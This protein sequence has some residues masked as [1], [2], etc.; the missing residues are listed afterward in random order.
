MEK[1]TWKTPEVV[2]VIVKRSKDQTELVT[3]DGKKHEPF[4]NGVLLIKR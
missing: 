4:E 1:K 2:S 3:K